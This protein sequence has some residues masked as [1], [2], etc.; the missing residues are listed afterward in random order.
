LALNVSKEIITAFVTINDKLALSGE[1][2]QQGTRSSFGDFDA[3]RLGIQQ[4]GNDPATLAAFEFWFDKAVR[5]QRRKYQIVHHILSESNEMIKMA[6]KEDWVEGTWKDESTG[7][8]YITELKSL[9]DIKAM[10]NYDIPTN[11]FIGGNP[12]QPIARGLALR[13]SIIAFR[14][15]V[16]REMG[17]YSFGGQQ[18]TF[19]AP[20]DTSM[21]EEALQTVNPDGTDREAIR[22]VYNALSVPETITV[23]HGGRTIDMPWP[24]VMFDHAPIV[25]AAAMLTALKVDVL[26]AESQA[27]DFFLSKID[28]PSFSFNKIQP[29][30]FAQTSYIN[31]GDS[32]GLQVMVAAFDSMKPMKL[33]YWINDSTRNPENVLKFESENPMDKLV[34]KNMPSGEHTI[35]GYTAVEIKGKEEWKPWDFNFAVGEPSGTVSLPEMRVLYR[36]YENVVEGAASGFPSYRLSASSNVRMTQRGQ[37]YIANPSSGN[38]ATISIMGVAQDGSTQNLGSFDFDVRPLPPP[39][40]SFGGATNGQKGSRSETRLFARYPEAITLKATFSITQWEMEFMGRTVRGQGNQISPEAQ[41]L[42]RQAQ[43]GATVTF[44]VDYR[45]PDGRVSKG[46]VTVKM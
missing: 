40:I 39:Q 31:R 41:N 4:Q 2:V 1:I 37:Q 23:R 7:N 22:R 19:E 43:A 27:I 20:A 32:L 29:L 35:Y 46:A 36:G 12:R 21:L 6:E 45:G 8:E 14:D 10:D 38:K 3:K 44:L 11:M 33:Q 28:A 15:Y 18:F 42:L 5:T 24:S 13:D 9:F 30:A 16:T 26:T 17:T 25:A 34:L